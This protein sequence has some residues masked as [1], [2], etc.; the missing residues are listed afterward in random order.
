M[1]RAVAVSL[2][3]PVSGLLG[4]SLEIAS[5]AA[6]TSTC[7]GGAYCLAV[8]A[9]SPLAYWRLHE[10]VSGSGAQDSSGYGRHATQIST[11]TFGL[12][13]LLPSGV[14]TSVRFP[15]NMS[16]FRVGSSTAP[17]PGSQMTLEMW[18]NAIPAA[19]A[20]FAGLI[21]NSDGSIT[22]GWIVSRSGVTSNIQVSI[23]TSGAANQ[24]VAVPNAFN[25]STHHFVMVLNSGTRT[26][27]LDGVQVV[28]SA[29]NHGSGFAA[30]AGLDLL[31]GQGLAAG[32]A[33]DATVSE[34]AIYGAALSSAR[35]SAHYAAALQTP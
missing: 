28:S 35:V 18:V 19:S 12:S 33:A 15:A 2:L 22:S 27:Y 23:G 10:T 34:I 14:G 29:Y 26:F 13:S 5:P 30:A 7:Q 21:G 32:G 9:D 24:W 20:N 31:I 4:C 16:G 6:D 3:L 25:G 8:M 1:V 17:N 11:P